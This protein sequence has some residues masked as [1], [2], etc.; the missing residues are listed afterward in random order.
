MNWQKR[1]CKRWMLTS[2]NST[3]SGSI[4][5]FFTTFHDVNMRFYANLCRNQKIFE[6]LQSL[7]NQGVQ[8]VYDDEKNLVRL[9]RQYMQI[10]NVRVRDE[11]FGAACRAGGHSKA[12]RGITRQTAGTWKTDYY[13]FATI[14]NGHKNKP[15]E[16]IL[17]SQEAFFMFSNLHLCHVFL[18]F[19]RRDHKCIH[20]LFWGQIHGF[21]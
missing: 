9:P 6:W 21:H 14:E 13:R 10:A 11:G 8:G 12:Y 18:L 3:K 1:S 16:E 20:C 7:K 15:L 19:G 4:Y 2:C 17:L 5:N